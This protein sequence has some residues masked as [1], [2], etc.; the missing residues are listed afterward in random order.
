MNFAI[1]GRKSVYS[2]KSDSVDNQQKM[3]RDYAEFNFKECIKSFETYSDEGFTGG[4]MNR[5]GLK[6]LL[7]DVK[8][9]VIDVVMVYQLDRISRSVKD[10]SN[11]YALFEEKN[12][13]FISIKE[14]IDT[15]TPIGRAMMYVTMVFAQVERENISAR[16][17]D[18][19]ICLA[20]KG[21]WVG[22]NP[23]Y[24][25]VRERI[26][27]NKKTHT[28]IAI[29]PEAAKFD[30]WIFDTFLENNYS[31]QRMETAFKNQ[32]IRTANGAFF[33][34]SQI[35]KILSMP[36][37]V[38]ATQSVYDYFARL[39]C[40]MD[41]GSPR[42]IWDG[43]HGVMVYG[44]S[45]EKNTKHTLQPYDK[46]LV[47]VGYH[48]PFISA[49]KWLAVQKRLKQ[50]I[51]DKTMKY[52]IPL[53]KGVL[54]CAKCGRLMAV[55]RK[56][57]NSGITSHYYCTKRMREGINACDARWTKCNIIDDKVMEIFKKIEADPGVIQ[58][59][60]ANK[61]I[62]VDYTKKIK[63]LEIT[64]QRLRTK[65]ERLT[66]SIAEIENSSAAKYI[67]AQIEKE[68][69]NLSA[70]KRMIEETKTEAR[71]KNTEK[72]SVEKIVKE[73]S[74]LMHSLDGLSSSEKNKIIRDVVQEC[75]WDGNTLF[76]ML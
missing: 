70:A 13:T 66:D 51:F 8:A 62:A 61:H 10:F 74:G 3:C 40:Q 33:S 20:K 60:V 35:Y 29:D 39:G 42:E 37:C 31:L 44:R 54:R 6:R 24:G 58:K 5:P 71:K 28:S 14:N 30:E 75:T 23:P 7:E 56:K 2:D 53:L 4:N 16:T 11:I 21:F 25:Y 50:N 57:T 17:A 1:Y 46:W 59:Y 49:N 67:I 26:K 15:T 76:L 47:C 65:I 9:G 18:N 45:T 73:I 64:V 38:E 48:K 36:Y 22:G 32:G 69:L 72:K 52:D 27:I 19:L 43:T 34:V 68:D 41:P 12:I 55:S 63:D